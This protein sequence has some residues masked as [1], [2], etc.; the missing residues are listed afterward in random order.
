MERPTDFPL[1]PGF[2][3]LGPVFYHQKVRCLLRSL[4]F[5][6]S[7]KN[8]GSVLLTLPRGWRASLK[9]IAISGH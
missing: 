5:S 9:C 8:T 7:R 3:D 4:C 1:H 2:L 6:P